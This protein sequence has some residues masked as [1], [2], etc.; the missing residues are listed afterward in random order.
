MLGGGS[1][2]SLAE[3][4]RISCVAAESDDDVGRDATTTVVAPP[5][6]ELLRPPLGPGFRLGLYFFIAGPAV[7]LGAASSA[8]S[9]PP[10]DRLRRPGLPDCAGDRANDDDDA[11]GTPLPPLPPPCGWCGGSAGRRRPTEEDPGLRPGFF[12]PTRSCAPPLASLRRV[13]SKRSAATVADV[14]CRRETALAGGGT[15]ASCGP[16]GAVPSAGGSSCSPETSA[17][18]LSGDWC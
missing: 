12:G 3:T 5:P 16:G 1:A 18:P 10:T 7:A 14:R 17:S 2:A 15:I 11:A 6:K 9:G 8:L 4:N 13:D